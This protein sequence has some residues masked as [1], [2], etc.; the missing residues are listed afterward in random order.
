MLTI[1]QAVE[2]QTTV[3][4][5]VTENVNF[6]TEN[7]QEVNEKVAL[8]SNVATSIADT[9]A[10]VNQSTRGIDTLSGNVNEN[11][12]EMSDLANRIAGMMKKFSM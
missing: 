4:V 3:I 5:D 1:G 11:L 12:S 9:L 6:A 2:E 10:D 8:S 7:I